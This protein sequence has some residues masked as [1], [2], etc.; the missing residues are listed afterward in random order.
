VQGAFRKESVHRG[1]E[2]R[3]GPHA[4]VSVACFSLFSVLARWMSPLRVFSLSHGSLE[5]LLLTHPIIFTVTA[6]YTFGQCEDCGLSP[7]SPI[8][9]FGMYGSPIN[10]NSATNPLARIHLGWTTL[11]TYRGKLS[12]NQLNPDSMSNPLGRYGSR[13]LPHPIH[14]PLGP[15]NP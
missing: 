8:N 2:D 9:P 12:T 3:R 4:P 11:R 1:H 6:A 13:L 10:P 5:A 15:G 7:F 14:N